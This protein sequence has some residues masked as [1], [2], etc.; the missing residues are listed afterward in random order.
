MSIHRSWNS[1][2]LTCALLL[3]AGCTADDPAESS[4][5]E[6][7]GAAE[8]GAMKQLIMGQDL[9]AIRGYMGSSCC[10][11]PDG[12]TA[13][14]DFY[15][16]LKPGD[17]GGLGIDAEGKP[18]DFEFSWGSGPNSAYVTA[19]GFGVSDIAIGL[20]ITENEHPGGLQR[21]VDGLQDDEIRQ[22]ARFSTMVDGKL[23]L[24][25]GYE[26]DG[27]WNHGYEN[28]DRY[29][30]A[31]RRIV[32]VLREEGAD[33]IEFVL[34]AGA[35]G[36]DE[37]IDGGH[38]DISKWYPGDEYV[39]WLALSWFMNPDEQSIVPQDNFTPLTPGQL[40]DEVLQLAREKGKPVMIAEASPQAMDLNEN[41]TAHHSPLWDGEPASNQ[42]PMS[43][44]EIWDYWFAPLFSYMETNR[45]VIHALAYI[46]V[47]WDSQPMWGPPYENGFWGDTRLETNPELARRFNQ[48]VTA[49][50]ANQ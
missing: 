47:D 6:D 7:A 50:K 42:Q 19:T 43:D 29:I 32:D 12:L 17:F 30:A 4:M 3:G 41:F 5:I 48:A 35:A 26:F 22:L 25:I 11:Q 46:N 10:V 37:I 36:V 1:L 45:D 34:Q 44:E 16:I 18:I 9:G 28:A 13:Y 14:L 2:L 38:E 8:P 21:I 39:D 24:R 20:S 40:S 27:A 23:Y 15:D 49:W 31:Y 33:N